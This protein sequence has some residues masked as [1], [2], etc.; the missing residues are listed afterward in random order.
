MFD[1]IL[2]AIAEYPYW[3]VALLFVLCGIGLPLP[4]EVLLLAAGYICKMYPERAELPLMMGACAGGILGGDVLPYVLGR[5]FGVRLLRLRWMRLVVT[6][7]RLAKFDGWF[8]RRGDWV[9]LIARFIPGLRVVAFFT[10]GTMKMPWRRFLFLDG[11]GIA[12][13]VPAMT[14]VGFHSAEYIDQAIGLVKRVEAGLLWTVMAGGVVL[15]GWFWVAQYRKRKAREAARQT[16]A[17]VQPQRPVEPVRPAADAAT[18]TLP[19]VRPQG[20][21]AAPS[22]VAPTSG[23]PPSAPDL[24]LDLEPLD[25]M[26]RVTRSEPAA[27]PPSDPPPQPPDSTRN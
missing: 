14:L 1:Q 8:R 21:T 9:I 24:V 4:E 25:E 18:P 15:V 5:V 22:T 12:L 20:P 2:A 11:L 17:F 7:Q 10:G 26:P 13:M 23:G 6:K 19:L 3:S 27:P 16:E